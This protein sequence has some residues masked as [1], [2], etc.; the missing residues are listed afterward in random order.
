MKFEFNFFP[1]LRNSLMLLSPSYEWWLKVAFHF[2]LRRH[3]AGW[4]HTGNAEPSLASFTSALLFYYPKS[5]FFCIYSSFLYYPK[6]S[7]F[8]IF[9]SFLYYPKFCFF[10]F[11]IYIF[12]FPFKC[13]S[14]VFGL[15][16]SHVNLLHM[17][18]SIF[19]AHEV[20]DKFHRINANE[21]L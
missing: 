2:H 6:F 3:L 4:R 15:R 8:C 18:F 20:L 14:N 10:C 13:E 19:G 12:I 17:S 5:N 9:Y 1:N 11:V 16:Y 7:F 21:S